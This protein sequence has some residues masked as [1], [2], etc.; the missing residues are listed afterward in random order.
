MKRTKPD[1]EKVVKRGV[2]LW[3]D[4]YQRMGQHIDLNRVG[5]FS[6]FIQDAI[7]EKLDRIENNSQ[8][9]EKLAS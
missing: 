9:T 4:Q 2:S 5:P 7:N 6:Q 3:P 1:S 8:E